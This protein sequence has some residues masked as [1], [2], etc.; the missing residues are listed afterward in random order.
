MN[1][2]TG[3]FGQTLTVGDTV[4]YPVRRGSAQWLVRGEIYDISRREDPRREGSELTDLKIKVN[5]ETCAWSGRWT[6]TERLTTV[7]RVEQVARIAT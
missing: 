3:A 2:A 5:A 6:Q 7:R 1:T 4:V